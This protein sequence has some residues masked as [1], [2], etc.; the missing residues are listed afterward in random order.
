[1]GR[2]LPDTLAPADTVP[3]W[4]GRTWPGTAPPRGTSPRWAGTFKTPGPGAPKWFTARTDLPA[5]C[6]EVLLF[7]QLTPSRPSAT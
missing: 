1:M 3:R 7:R 4:P 6:D 2:P 5:A